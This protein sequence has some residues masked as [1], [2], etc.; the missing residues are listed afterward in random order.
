MCNFVLSNTRKHVT[1]GLVSTLVGVLEIQWI[2]QQ[3]A[4]DH[5][6]APTSLTKTFEN[7]IAK[8]LTKYNNNIYIWV[9]IPNNPLFSRFQ[10]RILWMPNVDRKKLTAHACVRFLMANFNLTGI[11][12]EGMFSTKNRRWKV[13]MHTAWSIF[14]WHEVEKRDIRKLILWRRTSH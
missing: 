10:L 13:S 5:K 8:Y 11:L 9:R 14:R 2:G 3:A 6:S 4:V 7:A 12:F 1:K